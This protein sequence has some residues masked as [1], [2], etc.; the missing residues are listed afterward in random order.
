MATAASISQAEAIG[1]VRTLLRGVGWDGYEALLEWFGD[2]A[3]RM[4][5]LDGDVEF[6][7]PEYE[8]GKYD[9]L[10]GYMIGHIGD[11]FDIRVESFIALRLRKRS[12]KRGLEPD[13][14]YYFANADRVRAGEKVDLD[15]DP[16]PDLCVEIEITN[17]LLP[18]LKVYAGIGVP[19]IWRFDGEALTVLLLDPDGNY[20]ASGRS[21]SLP[22]VPI[23]E[24]QRFLLEYKQG[25][26]TAWRRRFR[27]WVHDV[28][29]PIHRDFPA[30]G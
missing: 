21:A 17:A 25:Q 30:E 4:T 12:K 23:G 15:V 14:C 5:C 28:L 24:L 27:T 9:Y 26:E 20:V 2:D 6:M 29:A 16:P 1:E 19:E 18:K 10:V 8:H 7:S 22:F 13:G 11:V 3:P